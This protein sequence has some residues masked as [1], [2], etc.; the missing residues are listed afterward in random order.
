MHAD[1]GH[2][3]AKWMDSRLSEL[4]V[5]LP[6][7]GRDESGRRLLPLDFCYCLEDGKFHRWTSEAIE[8]HYQ[9]H[10]SQGGSKRRKR[11]KET[12]AALEELYDSNPASMYAGDI[13]IPTDALSRSTVSF[14]LELFIIF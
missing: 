8:R 4:L 11:E 1:A 3:R 6:K 13:V 5:K 7:V 12:S 2:W 10:L 9:V 14:T